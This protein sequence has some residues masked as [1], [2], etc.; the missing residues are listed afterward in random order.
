MA[1]L[2]DDQ[3]RQL[4]AALGWQGGTF[5][6]VLEE[7]RRLRSPVPVTSSEC[8]VCLGTGHL[9]DYENKWPCSHCNGTGNAGVRV[10]HETPDGETA[11]P[12]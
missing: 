10:T 6:Q 3:L 2:N 5:W 7:V 8:S 9:E 12:I 1:D 4:C 11:W